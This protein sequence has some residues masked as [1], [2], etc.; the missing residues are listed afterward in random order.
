M[1][2]LYFQ[3]FDSEMQNKVTGANVN[4]QEGYYPPPS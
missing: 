3:T 1:A 4:A 2:K